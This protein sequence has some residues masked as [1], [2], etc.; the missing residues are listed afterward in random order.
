MKTVTASAKTPVEITQKPTLLIVEDEGEICFLINLLL[1]DKGL[2]IEH[3]KTISGA[4]EYLQ[5]QSPE[6][7]LLDNRLPDGFG[8]DFVRELKQK[9]PATKIIMISG[10]DAAAK[11]VALE[12][13]ADVF[14][15]KPFTKAV[16]WK[17][18]RQLLN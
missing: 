3:V 6:I 4:V 14:L 2:E 8:I 18:I 5:Q 13:G 1:N 10:V 12:N 16:L 9:Y 7:V 17:S 15:E 11:D